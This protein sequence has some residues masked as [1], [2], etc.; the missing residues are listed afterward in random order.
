MTKIKNSRIDWDIDDFN[1][2]VEHIRPI[3]I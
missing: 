3:L 2:R 1:W